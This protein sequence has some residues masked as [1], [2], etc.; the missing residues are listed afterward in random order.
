MNARTF[1]G[2]NGSAALAAAILLIGCGIAPD[3][4]ADSAIKN[5]KDRASR[6]AARS[7]KRFALNGNAH[8]ALARSNVK[9]RIAPFKVAA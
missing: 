8:A 4:A 1:K 6:S 2:Y 7:A 9:G 5:E 3:Q